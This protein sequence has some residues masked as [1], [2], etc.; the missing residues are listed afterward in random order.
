MSAREYAIP[1][2]ATHIE[3]YNLNIAPSS[4]SR[5]KR[6]VI[7]GTAED[8]PMYEPVSIDKPEDAELIWGRLTKGDLVRGVYE[9]WGAQEGN[10]NI[11]GVRIGNG[12]RARLEINE[13]DGYGIYEEQA[14][15]GTGLTSLILEAKFPG[16]YYNQLTI[17]RDENKNIVVFNPK[18]GVSRTFTVDFLNPAN[19][20]VEVHN[21]KELAD[22]INADRNLSR[23]VKASSPV[24]DCEYE[25]KVNSGTNGI[26]QNSTGITINL[27]DLIA[28]NPGV[29]VTTDAF[30]VKEPTLPY[31]LEEENNLIPKNLTVTNNIVELLDIESIS[32]SKLETIKT[33]GNT[34]VLAQAPLDGKGMADWDTLQALNDYNGDSKFIGT[35]AGEVVSE[36]TY[37]I[38]NVLINEVPTEPGRGFSFTSPLP[39]DD[40]EESISL[41]TPWNATTN[42]PALVDGVGVDGTTYR[43]SVAGSQF[44]RAP[45]PAIEFDVGDYVRFV[46]PPEGL[47]ADGI[48]IKIVDSPDI[49][50]DYCANESAYDDYVGVDRSYSAAFNSDIG[51][52]KKLVNGVLT[53]PE[54]KVEIYVS[55]RSDIGGSWTRVPYSDTYGI[56]ISEY[57]KTTGKTTFSIGSKVT[58]ADLVTSKNKKVGGVKFTNVT[59]LVEFDIN[60][61]PSIKEG[62]YVRIKA[63]TIKGFLTEVES[64]PQLESVSD[65]TVLTSYFIR[66]QEIVFNTPL[67]FP[68][69]VNYGTL[70]KYEIDTNVILSD[71]A[72]GQIKFTDPNYLPGP[73][74]AAFD[75]TDSFVRFKYTYL[76]NFPAI[77][78]AVKSLTGGTNGS[79]LTVKQREDELSKA[80]NYLRDFEANIWCPM[81]A[82]IDAK[83]EQYNSST[84]LKETVSN[85]FYNTINEFMEEQSINSIQP[86]AVLGVT[87]VD[88]EYSIEKRDLK[89][90][91]LTEIDFDDALKSANAMAY[92]QSKFVSVVAFEPVFMSLGRGKPYFSNGQAAYAGLLAALPYNLS[93]C[94]KPIP[95]VVAVRYDLSIRQHEM[96]NAMRYVTMRVKN[97]KPVIVNDVTGAPYGSDFTSWSVYSITAEAADRVKAVA[98]RYI[99]RDNSIAVRNAMDQEISNALTSMSGIQASNFIITS[100]MEQQIL[101]VVEIDIILVPIY[102]M[103][104]IRT[105]VKLRKNL[106]TGV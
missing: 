105:S 20:S 16:A 56:Y 31:G 82:Y 57:N 53:R 10:P 60:G 32:H 70:I 62:K 24:L 14:P 77:T 19:S 12:K 71:A 101:G 45:S 61:V 36:F 23:I 66:G 93:P 39:L 9:C 46:V 55:D 43:V 80:Y 92:V 90:V 51:V 18:T 68:I 54:G 72:K 106:P 85:N 52:E 91:D 27:K 95:G 25:V 37:V 69:N 81:G 65:S 84:G 89:V 33:N 75:G 94:N 98:E 15:S 50:I 21:V 76:P 48:W 103:K 83:A 41:R 63:N 99:G 74:G 35:P 1:S 30:I 11:V 42:S 86:H 6:V 59:S 58:P 44:E 67:P 102:T 2:T 17:K 96:M 7:I 40:S 87:Q 28:N 22:A 100:T 26:S 79:T 104:K 38:D 78:S 49:I 34:A 13:R 8:G 3:D 88:D 47:E 5:N 97:G 64:L 73:G 4:I 29:I